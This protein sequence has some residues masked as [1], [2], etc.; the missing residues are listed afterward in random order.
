MRCKYG[1]DKMRDWEVEELKWFNPEHPMF[2]L[3]RQYK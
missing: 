1:E 3:W 2:Q